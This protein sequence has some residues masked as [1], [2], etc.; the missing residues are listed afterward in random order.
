VGTVD[1][2]PN[3]LKIGVPATLG[4]VMGVADIIAKKRPFAADIT[5]C[6]HDGLLNALSKTTNYSKVTTLPSNT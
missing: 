2:G 4:N 1:N 6:C 3:S 5:T